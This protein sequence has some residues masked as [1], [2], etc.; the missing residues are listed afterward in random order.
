V[1]AIISHY[2]ELGFDV[3]K[4]EDLEVARRAAGG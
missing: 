2:P 1:A 4:V 3:D